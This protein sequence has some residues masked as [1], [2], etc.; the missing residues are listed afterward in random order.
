MLFKLDIQTTGDIL[1]DVYIYRWTMNLTESQ[2]PF[3]TK[4]ITTT[5]VVEN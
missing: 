1:R 5:I 4:F 2:L 3:V